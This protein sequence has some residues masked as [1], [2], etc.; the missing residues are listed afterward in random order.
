M[1]QYLDHLIP[2]DSIKASLLMYYSQNDPEPILIHGEF[3]LD[4]AIH[5]L[6]FLWHVDL[7]V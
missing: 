7:V 4:D 5:L 3:S 1:V 2:P 6:L